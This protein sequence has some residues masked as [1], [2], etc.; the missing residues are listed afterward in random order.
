MLVPCGWQHSPPSWMWS[1]HVRSSQ[2]QPWLVSGCSVIVFF[3]SLLSYGLEKGHPFLFLGVRPVSGNAHWSLKSN[4]VR[5]REALRSRSCLGF[6]ELEQV[7]VESVLE[8]RGQT[9]RGALVELQDRAL[10][11]L[12]LE[13]A[14]V[15]VRHDLLVGP[16]DDEGRDV[17]L[18]QVL[19]LIGFGERLDAEV[20]AGEAHH[21]ALPPEGLDNALR[22]FSARAVVAVERQGEVEPELRAVGVNTGA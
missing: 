12:V 4:C 6:A 19:G 9:V 2:H 14:R 10:D 1:D 5:L 8:R 13:Q 22:D 17:G 20:C 7:L 11:E 21:L 15:F 18:L 16:L 3:V